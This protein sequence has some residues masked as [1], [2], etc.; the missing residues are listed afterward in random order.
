MKISVIIPHYR[1]SA[2][3]KDALE[4]LRL[5]E[6]PELEVLLV[7][8]GCEEDLEDLLEEYK[9]LNIKVLTQAQNPESPRE[10]L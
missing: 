2:Y 3:L 9:V 1:G 10:L 7:K 6:Y 8:D 5:Q 4:S